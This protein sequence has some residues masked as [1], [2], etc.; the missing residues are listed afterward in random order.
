MKKIWYYRLF[1]SIVLIVIAVIV[2][3]YSV[4]NPFLLIIIPV[5]VPSVFFILELLVIP[6]FKE[7]EEKDRQKKSK[8]QKYEPIKEMIDL[9]EDYDN[10]EYVITEDN[11]NE[12]EVTQRLGELFPNLETIGFGYDDSNSLYDNFFKVHVTN[13]PVIH[14]FLIRPLKAGKPI[15]RLGYFSKKYQRDSDVNVLNAFIDHLKKKIKNR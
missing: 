6:R 11:L 14:Q 12:L 15:D 9:L 8:K 13:F 1:I 3:I 7:I 10:I 5:I 2:T 4:I